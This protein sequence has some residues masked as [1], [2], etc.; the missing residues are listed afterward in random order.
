MMYPTTQ[1]GVGSI[2]ETVPPLADDAFFSVLEVTRTKD[3]EVRNVVRDV[4]ERSDIR[5]LR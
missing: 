2:L 3:P 1:S 5:N 4:A